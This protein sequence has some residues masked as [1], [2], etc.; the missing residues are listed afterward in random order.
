MKTGAEFRTKLNRAQ[1]YGVQEVRACIVPENK[2]N[3]RE[4]ERNQ[5]L[6]LQ[7]EV[8]PLYIQDLPCIKALPMLGTLD[9]DLPVPRVSEKGCLTQRTAGLCP[10]NIG[11]TPQEQ[12]SKL[13]AGKS[14]VAK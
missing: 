10:R 6:A 12:E 11:L 1:M 13:Q 2:W 9:L 7:V 3:L 8:D 4:S 14:N 5:R